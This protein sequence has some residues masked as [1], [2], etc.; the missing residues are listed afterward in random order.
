M[1]LLNLLGFAIFLLSFAY[2]SACYV[3]NC[4]VANCN[5]ANCNV[6]NCISNGNGYN[7]ATILLVSAAK[8][9]LV[10]AANFAIFCYNFAQFC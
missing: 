3:A 9:L 7:F 4:N 8:V 6:A 1:T 5:V 10:S 2:H